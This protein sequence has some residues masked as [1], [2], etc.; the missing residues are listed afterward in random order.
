MSWFQF[1]FPDFCYAFISILLEGV[2]FVLLGTLLSGLI[3]QFLPAKFLYRILPKNRGASIL[4]SG[5]VG[6]VLPMCECGIVP[7]IRRLIRKGLSIPSAVTYMLSAPIVN[8][9]VAVSTFMAFKGQSALEMTSL[10]LGLGYL[11]AVGVGFVVLRLKPETILRESALPDAEETDRHSHHEHEHEHE[12]EHAPGLA[13]RLRLALAAAVTDFL[14]VIVFFV[15]GAMIAA[16]FNTAVDQTV[17]L[18]LA[19]DTTLATFALMGLAGI[20]TLCST[21]DAFVAATL[22]AFPPVA[23]LAFLVFGPMMDVKLA[24]IYSALFRKRFVIGLAVALFLVIGVV[25]V[26]LSFLRL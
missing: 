8:P 7:V 3:D 11:I 21:S 23:K 18:P 25:C 2:P 26:R 16:T 13:T 22:T 19:L 5:L 24:F 20:L 6:L 12:H 10:R 14:D 9:I 1:S 17:I 4:V 15:L